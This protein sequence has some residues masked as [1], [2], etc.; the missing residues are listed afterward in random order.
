MKRAA[1]SAVVGLVAAGSAAGVAEAASADRLGAGEEAGV[2]GGGGRRRAW[3]GAGVEGASRF[4]CNAESTFS[5]IV[6]LC[7]A[8]VQLCPAAD[9]SSGGRAD[10]LSFEVSL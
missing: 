8:A 7:R 1:V 9:Q 6:L 5:T 4:S 2:E 10:A 3:K